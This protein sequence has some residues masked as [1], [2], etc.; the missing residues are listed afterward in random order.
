MPGPGP[1]VSQ[2]QT[3]ALLMAAAGVA[4]LVLALALEAQ[5]RPGRVRTRT[6]SALVGALLMTAGLALLLVRRL[7]PAALSRVLANVTAAMFAA[8]VA[9][10]EGD[11]RP[12]PADSTACTVATSS[13]SSSLLAPRSIEGAVMTVYVDDMRREGRVHRGGGRS[14]TGRWSHL[15]ADDPDELADVRRGP[16]T[17]TG[18]DPAARHAAGAL[19]RRRAPTPTRHRRRSRPDLL[20]ARHRQ[21]DRHQAAPG[22]RPG[23]RRPRLARLPAAAGNEGP[24][25]QALGARSDHRHRA[26][27]ASCGALSCD[28]ATGGTSRSRATSGSPAGRRVLSCSTSTWP[29]PARTAPGGRCSGATTTSR[30]AR[31]CSPCLAEQVGQS[32]PETYV[33]ATPSGGRHL[34]FAAPDGRAGP[35]LHRPSRPDD[36]RPRQRRLRRRRR[37]PAPSAS[38]SRR[39]RRR[40][41]RAG[42]PPGQRRPSGR[43]SRLA[44]RRSQPATGS[45][46]TR[47]PLA[48][49]RE[50]PGI[51]P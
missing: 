3:V 19:R 22:L 38:R 1:A 33:V 47:R 12:R 44:D 35:Q 17:P 36:R 18:V 21:P 51:S 42:L 14:I 2:G 43:T 45:E 34:Y 20:P 50:A 48:P 4:L 30:Q 11:G 39:R 28:G 15:L 46:T 10:Q 31:T 32:V 23:R 6:R 7:D 29:S 13:A 26:D 41:R 40:D 37:L 24:G 49:A 8:A 16:R 25:G 9:E 27:Q 5:S